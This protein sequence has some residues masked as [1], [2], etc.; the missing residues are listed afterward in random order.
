[1]R[2]SRRRRAINLITIN[3]YKDVVKAMRKAII[4]KK[5]GEAQKLLPAVFKQLDKAVK[6]H[7]IHKNKTARLKSRLSKALGKI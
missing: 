3:K 1:M 7:V 6:K 4:A 2:Q 5:K